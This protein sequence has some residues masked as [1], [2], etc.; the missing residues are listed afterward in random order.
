MTQIIFDKSFPETLKPVVEPILERYKLLLPHWM[1]ELFVRYDSENVADTANAFTS[2][3][4]RWGYLTIC[5]AF[6]EAD[7]LDG[8]LIHEI[9]HL[10]NLPFV[11]Y[12]KE[13]TETFVED[14]NYKDLIMNEI[15]RKMEAMTDDIA[16]AFQRSKGN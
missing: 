11:N 15:N 4:Y 12:V 2:K 3:E 14:D 10:H 13:I 5:S 6:V 1:T 9:I 8:L 7:D 16:Y